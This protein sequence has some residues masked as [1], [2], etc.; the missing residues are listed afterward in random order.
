MV[1]F[2]VPLIYGT[3]KIFFS[4]YW[5]ITI[6]NNYNFKEQQTNNITEKASPL[7]TDF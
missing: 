7:L 2:I 3:M 6:I 5:I 1:A 4:T